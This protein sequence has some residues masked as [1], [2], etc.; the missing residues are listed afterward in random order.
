LPCQPA[1]QAKNALAAGQL[2]RKIYQREP[3]PV[4]V[5]AYL[6]EI[7][8]QLKISSRSGFSTVGHTGTWILD[9][10]ACGEL[11]ATDVEVILHQQVDSAKQESPRL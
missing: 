10:N 2:L 8:M 7:G 1:E 11:T 3:I 5:D 9:P 4:G 6:I